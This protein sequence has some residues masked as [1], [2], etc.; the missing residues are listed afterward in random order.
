VCGSQT[1]VVIKRRVH[2]SGDAYATVG[3]Y[4]SG[5]ACAGTACTFADATVTRG[6]AYDY[7]LYTVI[8]DPAAATP[9]L[10]F[11]EL[12]GSVS[13]AVLDGVPKPTV[14]KDS[15]TAVT[16]TWTAV[17]GAEDYNVQR[18]ANTTTPSF[19]TYAIGVTELSYQ[20]T[21]VVT[22]TEYV[23]RVVPRAGGVTALASQSVA[24]DPVT[25]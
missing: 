23:Y 3:D 25:P 20:D 1:N 12:W 21:T 9:A 22:G 6:T 2:G 4:A 17:P 8:Q 15:P 18:A 13:Y 7:R 16:V 10:T 11:T 5:V 24:S 14:T 19:S